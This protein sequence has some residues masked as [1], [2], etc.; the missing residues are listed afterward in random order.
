MSLWS[1]AQET[2]KNEIN[3]SKISEIFIFQAPT[4]VKTKNTLQKTPRQRR[5]NSQHGLNSH[6]NLIY[7]QLK[8]EQNILFCYFEN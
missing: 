8:I 3:T 7:E 6:K 5:L 4:A 1:Q 2:D